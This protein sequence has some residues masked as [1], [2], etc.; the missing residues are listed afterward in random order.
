MHSI[1]LGS[2]LALQQNE[3]MNVFAD[4]YND[5]F[6]VDGVFGNKTDNNLKE[7]QSFTDLEFSKD[8]TISGIDWHPSIKG[9]CYDP[10]RLHYQNRIDS[11]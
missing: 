2:K 8:K 7:Y 11:V 5:L 9:M 6:D 10:G 4:D 1:L 3:I